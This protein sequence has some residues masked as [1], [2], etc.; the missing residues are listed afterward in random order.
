M[1]LVLKV[2]NLKDADV[3][4]TLFLVDGTV[5]L[6][7]PAACVRQMIGYKCFQNRQI[8]ECHN[9]YLE[10]P[11][12]M[13]SNKYTNMPGIVL[14]VLNLKHFDEDLRRKQTNIVHG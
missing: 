8:L 14:V 11:W 4:P 7:I 10:S 5:P 2:Q 12:K 13:H 9:Y 1:D 3:L 6:P